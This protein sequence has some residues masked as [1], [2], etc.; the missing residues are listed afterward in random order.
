MAVVQSSQWTCGALARAGGIDGAGGELLEAVGADVEA[1]VCITAAAWSGRRGPLD[2]R[3]SAAAVRIGGILGDHD[4]A[5]RFTGGDD[6][7]GESVE[8]GL[9][10]TGD[11]GGVGGL[12]DD[13]EIPHEQAGA[14]LDEGETE[15]DVAVVVSL[16]E[17]EDVAE[18]SVEPRELP[19]LV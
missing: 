3:L 5:V 13:V 19:E 16:P 2:V 18:T 9:D 12:V 14:P 17:L 10:H 1:A 4:A 6:V 11:V 7:S 15:D 8:L